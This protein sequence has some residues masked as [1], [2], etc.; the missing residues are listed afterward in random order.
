MAFEII[1]PKAGLDMTEGQIV[2]W[3][4]KEGDPVKEGEIILEIM[5]DKTSMEIEAEAS[6]ILLKIVHNDG[7]TVPVTEVIGY[8]GDENESVDTLMPEVIED[9]GE[10][11][12]EE[13]KRMIRLEDNYNVVVIGGGPAGYV[14]AI[15]AAQ[16]GARVAIVE[17]GEFGGTCLNVGCIPTKA[18]LKNAEIIEHI[19]EASSRG[20]LIDSSQIKVDME[21]VQEFKNGVVKKL[22]SG[23]VA[24]LKSNGVDIYQGVGK[25]N[26]NKDVVVNDS[27][28]LKA[29]KIILAGGSK[30][31]KINIPGIESDKV[32]TSDDLLAIKE[33]PETLAVIGGGV[34]GTEMGQSFA[35]LG[36]KVIIIEM[37]DRI[38]PP[39]DHEVSAEL[40]KIIKKKG[41][42]VITSARITEIIDK[43]DKLEIKI[44]GKESVIADKALISIGRVPDLDGIGEMKFETERGKIKVD[45][46]M[47]TSVKGIYAPGDVNGIKMLAHVAF[48]MGE[49]AAENAVKGNERSI[50][51]LSA[52]SVVYTSPEVAMVGLTEEEARA[53][54][55]D[56]RIGRFS[57]A[58]NG[59]A[60]ASSEA[61]G[62]VKVIADNRYGEVLGVHII[63]PSAAEIITQA[64]LIM[65]MEITVDEVIK[66]IY[67]HP[68][69][70]EALF[71]AFADVLGEAVH[72]PKKKK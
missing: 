39:L 33:V 70:S 16:L 3:L 41:M 31:S 64:S 60:L 66:T 8:I 69:Y 6:G 62:F 44:D 30:A 10:K 21:K 20:I 67:G 51:L 17:K 38:V 42:T 12:S 29:D 53:K 11:E 27:Q 71:E 40:T 56:I 63:G 34:I 35:G 54:Y 46:Y 47:E 50:K 65:E 37:M 59:R 72:I 22:T 55:D 2:K 48:R 61:H 4:K 57:F 24:L 18:Y 9:T 1:M 15:K 13:D 36:S 28:I 45:K 14:A 52:P 19:R 5:T 58:A 32:L 25:I 49:V 68:T 7:D 23:V 43:G 26:K